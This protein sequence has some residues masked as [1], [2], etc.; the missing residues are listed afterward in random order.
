[1]QCVSFREQSKVPPLVHLIRLPIC[2]RLCSTAHTMVIKSGQLS[3]LYISQSCGSEASFSLTFILYCQFL[4]LT[5]YT[6]PV[7]AS[8]VPILTVFDRIRTTLATFSL[9]PSLLLHPHPTS[10]SCPFS[11]CPFQVLSVSVFMPCPGALTIASKLDWGGVGGGSSTHFL[12]VSSS[13]FSTAYSMFPVDDSQV[14]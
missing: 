8:L 11:K 7:F 2:S 10:S 9:P 5:V 12:S 14:Q 1:M 3:F 6:K 4:T 13:S